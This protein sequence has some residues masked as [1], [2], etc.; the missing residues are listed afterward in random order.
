MGHRTR[1]GDGTRERIG[2]H[3]WVRLPRP[4]TERSAAPAADR[5]THDRPARPSDRDLQA[6]GAFPGAR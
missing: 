3:A 5:P 1:Y 6:E 2:G 4:E